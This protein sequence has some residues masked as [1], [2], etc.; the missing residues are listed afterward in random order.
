VTRAPLKAPLPFAH[1]LLGLGAH[2][3]LYTI[4]AIVVRAG[5]LLLIPIYWRFLDPADYGVITTTGMVS[6]FLGVVFGLGL[7]ES[8]TQFFHVWSPEERR[9][10][11]GAIWMADWLSSLAMGFVLIAVGGPLFGSLIEKVPWEPYLK[12]G[13]WAGMLGSLALSPMSTLRAREAPGLYLA[14]TAVSFALTST[15]SLL[16]LAGLR[17]GVVGLLQAQVLA[18]LAMTVVYAL[19]MRRWATPNLSLRRLRPALRFSLPLLPTSVLEGLHGVV[20]RFML[21]KRVSLSELGIYGVSNQLAGPVRLLHTGVKTAWLPFQLRAASQ[22]EDARGTIGRLAPFFLL[23]VTAG[24][25]AVAVLVRDGVLLLAF[26]R[27]LPV[28]RYLGLAVLVPAGFTL[29]TLFGGGLR[30]T[31]RTEYHPVIAA[32]FMATAI[33]G[34]WQ[35][36]PRLGLLGAFLSTVAAV[37]VRG[38]LLFVA[39]QRLYRVP[40]EWGKI[41]AILAGALLTYL[42]AAGLSPRSPLFALAAHAALLAV[43][44]AVMVYLLLDRRLAHLRRLIPPEEAPPA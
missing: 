12:L 37:V 27:Y 29:S 25:L 32:V 41:A 9:R 4:G 24:S 16:A 35:L 38:T 21:E 44:V 22:H 8:I 23:A 43:Y 36:I 30:I 17:L 11:L 40:F 10:G 33:L 31:G 15:F 13:V 5:E 20:D 1:T 2:T 18:Q 39:S 26:E 28:T 7:P 34:Y 6:S 42:A 14:C 3:S 19:L